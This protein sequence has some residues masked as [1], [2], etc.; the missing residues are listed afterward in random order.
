MTVIVERKRSRPPTQVLRLEEL[1]VDIEDPMMKDARRDENGLELHVTDSAHDFKHLLH[2]LYDGF[3]YMKSV[4]PM[5]FCDLASAARLAHK[6]SIFSILN[7]CLEHLEAFFPSTI[8]DWDKHESLRAPSSRSFSPQNAI[9]A[10]ILLRSLPPTGPAGAMLPAAY[11]LAAQLPSIVISTGARR[12]DGTLET[13]AQ[14]D[15]DHVYALQKEL[16]VDAVDAHSAV[17]KGV[18]EG[19]K[20]GLFRS[21]RAG[22]ERAEKDFRRAAVHGDPL[23]DALRLEIV[24][25]AGDKYRVCGP[26]IAALWKREGESRKKIWD[27]LHEG[28][29]RGEQPAD[30]GKAAGGKAK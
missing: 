19:C 15:L 25:L 8:D 27:K 9:E 30:S 24:G 16:V 10:V 21:C 3:E 17:Y 11:Y 12:V 7:Q 28:P 5:E 1:Y 26:C 4:K 14:P 13:L 2:I 6:Y 22:L 18:P 29:R 23:G 20:A